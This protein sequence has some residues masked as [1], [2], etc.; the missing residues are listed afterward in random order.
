[1]GEFTKLEDPKIDLL[2]RE[3]LDRIVEAVLSR[4]SP[5][6]LFYVEVL[7]EERAVYCW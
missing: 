7:E 5:F 1:M 6:Q 3:H 4:F 2:I